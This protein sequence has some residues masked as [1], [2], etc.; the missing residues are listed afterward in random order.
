VSL[1]QQENP[2]NDVSPHA[3]STHLRVQ[4][5]NCD[6]S[7]EKSKNVV[8]SYDPVFKGF[9]TAAEDVGNLPARAL[10]SYVEPSRSLGSCLEAT[11]NSVRTRSL[12][13]SEHLVQRCVHGGFDL[14]LHAHGKPTVHPCFQHEVCSRCT[15]WSQVKLHAYMVS[16]KTTQ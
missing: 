6:A 4:V 11:N 10:S 15:V 8:C 2:D 7:G 5:Y 1:L 14:R 3:H 16:A 13:C 12:L 9:C